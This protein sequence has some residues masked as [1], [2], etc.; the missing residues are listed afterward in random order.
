MALI[1]VYLD[2]DVH[3]LIAD[4]LRLRG[5]DALTTIEAGYILTKTQPKCMEQETTKLT[6][7]RIGLRLP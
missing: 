4:A 2:E 5:W 1:R 6:A 3:N 7:R